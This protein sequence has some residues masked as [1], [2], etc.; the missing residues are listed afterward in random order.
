[1]S[2]I[3]FI[4]PKGISGSL[5][6]LMRGFYSYYSLN[7]KFEIDVKFTPKDSLWDIISGK[8]HYDL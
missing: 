2:Y 5:S 3:S 4:Q 6:A 1:M 8:I 7:V